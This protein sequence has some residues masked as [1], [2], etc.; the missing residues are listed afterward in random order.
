M[1]NI[2]LLAKHLAKIENLQER[3]L[4][5]YKALSD[6][7]LKG[8]KEGARIYREELNRRIK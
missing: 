1:E 7:Y 3:K 5:I 6:Q 8:M 2:N 4:R